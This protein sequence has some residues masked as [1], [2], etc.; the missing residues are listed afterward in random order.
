MTGGFL[1]VILLGGGVVGVF[2]TAN[3][4]IADEISSMI[5]ALKLASQQAVNAGQVSTDGHGNLVYTEDAA[6]TIKNMEDSYGERIDTMV[7][8]P[9]N[10]RKGALDA[11]L[12]FSGKSNANVVYSETVPSGYNPRVLEEVYVVGLDQYEVNVA[13][14][15]IIQFGP[16]PLVLGEVTKIY[17]SGSLSVTKLKA[18]AMEKIANTS[19]VHLAELTASTGG[20]VDNYFFRW[21]DSSRTVEGMHPFIQ[22]GISSGGEIESYTNTLSL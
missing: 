8:R 14:N 17:T 21:E 16:R 10:E 20:K 11:I 13:N 18:L 12:A 6:I 3:P 5:S 7:A 1:A 9:A 2:A 22:V 15:Q 4:S 19:K